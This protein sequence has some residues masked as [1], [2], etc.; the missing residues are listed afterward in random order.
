MVLVSDWLN[1][2]LEKNGSVE[3]GGKKSDE[4]ITGCSVFEIV[5]SEAIDVDDEEDE[6]GSRS[7]ENVLAVGKLRSGN[8]WWLTVVLDVVFDIDLPVI[9]VSSTIE[10]SESIGG[11]TLTNWLLEVSEL[12]LV[13]S[14]IGR[15]VLVKFSSRWLVGLLSAY[16]FFILGC[17]FDIYI[18]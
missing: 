7:I 17:D 6:N 16:S 5:F 3:L 11:K 15:D 12:I 14:L 18:Y 1:G 2:V 10:L 9:S 8:F 4:S 13:R